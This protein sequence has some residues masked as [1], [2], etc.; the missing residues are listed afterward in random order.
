MMRISECDVIFLSYD[1][2][3][4]EYNWSLLLDKVPWAQRVHG[5]KG[6]DSAHKEASNISSTPWFVTVDA[7]NIVYDKFWDIEVNPEE[8]KS[9]YWKGRNIINGN[10]S[11]N[12]GVKLWNRDFV[13]SM[14]THEHSRH[15]NTDLDF[16]NIYGYTPMNECYSDSYANGSPYQA[17]RAGYR[18]CV[19]LSSRMGTRKISI[20]DFS[21]RTDHLHRKRIQIFTSV[22]QDVE[23]GIWCIFGAR[24]GV[25]QSLIEWDITQISDYEWFELTW[26]K[27]EQAYNTEE[28]VINHVLEMGKDIQKNV[29]FKVPL[30]SGEESIWF[31]EIL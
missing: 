16:T 3:N 1:E 15:P 9:Y 24:Q 11:G 4:A 7:D 27:I 30:L 29:S 8:G 21:S 22:G 10:V 25:L 31:K 12:G 20:K 14:R 19:K 5:V 23:N 6:F 28:K 13:Q 17:W 26:N 2:P 18:E